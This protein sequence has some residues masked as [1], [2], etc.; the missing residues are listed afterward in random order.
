MYKGSDSSKSCKYKLSVIGYHAPVID[1]VTR[2]IL[3][4]TATAI[5]YAVT[6]IILHITEFICKDI[7]IIS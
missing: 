4:I 2:I 1:T 7:F 3:H 5:I 6:K